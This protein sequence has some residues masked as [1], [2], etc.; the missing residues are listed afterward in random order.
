MKLGVIYPQIEMG[1]EAAAVR[2]F[3]LAA[4]QL[5]FDYLVAYDHVL[6]AEHAGREPQLTGPYTEND[7]FHDP[8]TMFAYLAGITQT[9]EFASG[10][11]ILPQRQ[12]AL[13]AKQAGDV[14]AFSGGRLRLGVG[15]G[16]NHVE[17]AALGKEFRNRAKRMEEQ[18]PL[19]RRLWSETV[20]SHQGRYEQID[21]AGLVFLPKKPIEIWVGAN[22][23]A[24]QL[25]GARL[26]DGLMLTRPVDVAMEHAAVALAARREM[27][28]T[29]P[30]G[31]EHLH[32]R[33][34]APAQAVA[35]S[36]RRWRD[37]GGT[38]A[39]VSTMGRDL[40]PVEAHIDFIAEVRRLSA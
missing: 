14:A 4:E 11:L 39:S 32:N 36:F 3:G 38:H 24:A 40:G 29:A 31:L 13:V 9:L 19:L 35:D 5:G 12:T 22:V 23:E 18:I 25:R 10:I 17:Y 21:R 1:G 30:F 7:P 20:V 33:G 16:W 2:S 37:F 8:L 26:A 34:T 28:L 6:G 15:L 27:G